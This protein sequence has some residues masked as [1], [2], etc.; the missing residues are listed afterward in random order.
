[1]TRLK[2]LPDLH[3]LPQ[4]RK[5]WVRGTP[6]ST[7]DPSS[8]YYEKEYVEYTSNGKAERMGFVDEV[9]DISDTE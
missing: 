5:V 1:L 4:L 3:H 2:G 7:T 6:L 9:S 8:L